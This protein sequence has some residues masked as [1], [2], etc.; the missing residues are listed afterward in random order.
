MLAPIKLCRYAHQGWHVGIKRSI[1]TSF[2]IHLHN[3]FNLKVLPI[4]LDL[5]VLSH[6]RLTVI[7]MLFPYIRSGIPKNGKKTTFPARQKAIEFLHKP[8]SL[9]L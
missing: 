5:N 7:I 8:V 2:C 9:P 1:H 6:R 3:N 4:V